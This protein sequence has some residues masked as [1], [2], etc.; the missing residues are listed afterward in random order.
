MFN[1]NH[2]KQYLPQ[3]KNDQNIEWVT[4]KIQTNVQS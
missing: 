3:Y 4:R 1:E 2:L